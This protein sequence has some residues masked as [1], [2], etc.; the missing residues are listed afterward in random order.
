MRH[1]SNL[2][3]TH[4]KNEAHEKAKDIL[5]LIK[6]QHD[7]LRQSIAILRNENS[8]S[9]TKQDQLAKF[10]NLLTMHTE[11]EEQT[12]YDVLKDIQA[13]ELTTLEAFEEHDIAQKLVQELEDADYKSTWN[14]HIAAKAKVLADIV[15]HHAKEEEHVFFKEARSLL[16]KDE[17]IN[18]G[19]EFQQKCA[20]LKEGIHVP[21]H[22][23][24]YGIHSRL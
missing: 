10:I 6:D 15:D 9:V 24:N 4:L 16:T 2:H 5:S 7:I 21:L 14:T 20:E 17:L 1:G 3:R 23:P 22:S 18:L 13:S 8:D 11:A 12:I 19:E